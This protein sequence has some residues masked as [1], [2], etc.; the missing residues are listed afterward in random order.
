M[1]KGVLLARPLDLMWGMVSVKEW[2]SW[3][4]KQLAN[5]LEKVLEAQ[6]AMLW[7]AMMGKLKVI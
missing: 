4:G 1:Q 7:D 6:W 3:L 2:A 5:N